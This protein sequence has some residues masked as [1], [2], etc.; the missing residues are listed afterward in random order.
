MLRATA[1]SI[2]TAPTG[3]WPTAV[4]WESITASVPSRIAFA[5]SVTSAR[6]GRDDVTIE[7]SICVAVIAG[8]AQAPAR[9]SSF[10]CA[11]GTSSI[12]SSI[13]RSPRAT[14]MQS[15]TWR[16]SA[17]RS[18]ACGFSI[19]AMSGTRVCSRTWVTSS[20]RRTNESATMSTPMRAPASRCARSS[21]GTDGSAAV[22]PGMFTPW[23]DATVPPISTSA[24]SSCSPAR[25]ACVRRR[26][27]PSAR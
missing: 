10:F 22:S 19:L 25:T 8:R 18:T 11:I 1:S 5:T 2:S 9:A 14:M 13:P 7:S 12:G 4:S 3:Y 23:R 17:A 6:V 27:A 24:S 20:G 26:T 15:E 16:I 21:C